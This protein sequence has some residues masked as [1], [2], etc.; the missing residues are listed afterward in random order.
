VDVLGVVTRKPGCMASGGGGAA[1]AHPEHRDFSSAAAEEPP[2]SVA[3]SRLFLAAG[4][5]EM[6]DDGLSKP[7][8]KSL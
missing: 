6:V 2:E 3:D 7:T 1:Q 5:E 4:S 8:P